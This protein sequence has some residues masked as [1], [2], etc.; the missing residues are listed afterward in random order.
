MEKT[1]NL[2]HQPR[3]LTSWKIW[4]SWVWASSIVV[5]RP[6]HIAPWEGPLKRFPGRNWDFSWN[7]LRRFSA[8]CGTTPIGRAS[9]TWMELRGGFLHAHMEIN[10][11]ICLSG[12]W[13]GTWILLFHIYWEFHH[14]NWR[15]HIFQRGR[16][17]TN[18]ISL[19]AGNSDGKRYWD[20]RPSA[21][22]RNV[23]LR[24]DITKVYDVANHLS[25]VFVE[26]CWLII[27][28]DQSLYTIRCTLCRI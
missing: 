18:Q 9:A 2:N 13:F 11:R 7:V 8:S 27:W 12:W 15:T 26:Q 19:I 17:T 1:T 3:F 5:C 24:L 25:I 28:S 21:I 22:L 6:G 14:P 20:R 10:G 4:M 23:N 16:Y